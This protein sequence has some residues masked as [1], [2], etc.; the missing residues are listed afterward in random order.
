MA[1]LTVRGVHFSSQN[2]IQADIQS[3]RPLP[4]MKLDVS[5]RLIWALRGLSRSTDRVTGSK[6]KT[7]R[8]RRERAN[9]EEMEEDQPLSSLEAPRAP[10]LDTEEG[11]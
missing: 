1:H 7:V 8:E 9:M 2:C 6:N 4:H 5:E 3:P 10:A 11:R